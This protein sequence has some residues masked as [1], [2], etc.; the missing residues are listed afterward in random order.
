MG[1]GKIILSGAERTIIAGLGHPVY[2][3]EFVEEWVNW[4]G[5]VLINVFAGMQSCSAR[6]FYEAVKLMAEGRGKND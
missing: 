5:S 6:G 3:A 4:K 2:T 1:S